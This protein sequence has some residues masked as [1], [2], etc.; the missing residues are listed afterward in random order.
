MVQVN[1][2]RI[3]EILSQSPTAENFATYAACRQ[4]NTKGGISPLR[5][6]RRQMRK[7]GFTP[8]PQELLSMFKELDRAGVGALK[9]GSFKWL[10][11]IRDLG[12]LAAKDKQ[13]PKVEPK[14]EPLAVPRS[15]D[16]GR[17][18]VVFGVDRTVTVEYPGDI[19]PEERDFVCGLITGSKPK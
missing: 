6:I 18:V 10:L 8:V 5:E 1:E 15:P 19:S 13:G 16:R 4:R 14:P 2:K 3:S 12:H 17:L 11:P 9:D 7:E